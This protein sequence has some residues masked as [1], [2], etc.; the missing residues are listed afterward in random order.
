MASPLKALREHLD[1]S[2]SDLA[3]ALGVSKGRICQVEKGR[4]SFSADRW[5]RFASLYRPTIAEL[6]FEMEDFLRGR[7]RK[8]RAA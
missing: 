6:G 3:A 8:R 5:A 4:G 1:L 2:Q 7:A